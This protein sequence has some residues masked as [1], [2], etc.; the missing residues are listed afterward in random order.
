MID[1]YSYTLLNYKTISF[2][3]CI[4]CNSIDEFLFKKFHAK[5]AQIKLIDAII[6]RNN[7]L[8][9]VHRSIL[10]HTTYAKNPPIPSLL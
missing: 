7:R 6:N 5:K 3:M 9:N 8:S 10:T 2:Y 4:S 1:K